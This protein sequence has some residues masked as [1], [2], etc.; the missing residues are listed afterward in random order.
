MKMY[1]KLFEICKEYSSHVMNYLC[2]NSGSKRKCSHADSGSDNCQVL[3]R[4]FD[5]VQASDKWEI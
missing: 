5:E 1:A 3:S 2:P 4:L